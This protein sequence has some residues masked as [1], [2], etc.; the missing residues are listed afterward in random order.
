MNL[1]IVSLK[2]QT[3][4]IL[5][6]FCF[7]V[8]F[9]Q[10]YKNFTISNGLAGNDIK[11]IFKD[12]NGLMWIATGSGLCTYDGN[13][14]NIIGEDKGL[15]H[16]L[17][18]KITE[19]N[20]K[21]IWFSL[22]GNGVAKYDGR[23]FT[24]FTE[25]NGLINNSVR[26]L[27]YSKKHK[28]MVF[29]TE[30][31][32]S[33]F[34]GKKFKSFKLKINNPTKK[35][36]VNFI[37]EYKEKIVF[38]VNH[39]NI[40]E[41]N[42]NQI[43]IEKSQLTKFTSFDTKNYS[44]F[45][46]GDNFYGHT[47]S[48]DFGIYNLKTNQKS[49]FGNS[50]VIW[51]YTIDNKNQ[52]Y[53]SCW[54]VNSPS[55]ALLCFN[56][57]K[58]INLSDKLKLPTSLFWCLYFDKITNQLWVG[59][60]DKGVFVIDLSK[61]VNY[62]NKDVL[63]ISKPE[64]NTICIDNKNNIWIGGI[65]FIAIKNSKETKVLSNKSLTVQ[66]LNLIKNKFDF[67]SI[68]LKKTLK[69]SNNF[70]CNSIKIDESGNILALTNYGLISLDENLKVLKY[71][72]IS[73]TGGVFDIIDSKNILLSHNYSYSYKVNLNNLD[74]YQI[75]NYKNKE[76]IISAKRIF[77]SQNSL[78]IASSSKGLF[79]Y[80]RDTLKSMKDLGYLDEENIK[81][82]IV[83]SNKNVITGSV[84]GKVYFNRWKN[85][86]LSIFKIL[87]PEK[88]IIGNS[89]FFIKQYKNYYFIGTNK[90]LNII[91]DFKLIKFI[92]ETENLEQTIYTDAQIDYINYR[93]LISTNNG[94]ISVDL[95]NILKDEKVNSLLKITTIKVNNELIKN[96]S[97]LTLE[98]FENN[99]EISFNS[100]NIYNAS[101]NRY[102]YKIIGLN[103]KWSSYSNDNQI[104]LIGLTHG[105]YQ[106][107]IE[108]KN[109]GTN[110]SISPI[111]LNIIIN[112]PFWKTNWFVII[113][114]FT[115]S[116]FVYVYISNKIKSIKQKADL[117]KRI[118]ETKLQALQSQM[119]PHFV[120]N[121]MNSIQ[122]FVIDNK[123]DEALWYM[124]EF[125]KLMRQTLNYSSKSFIQLEEE[126]DYLK[127]YIELENLR[128]KNKVDYS[129][130]IA[131]E[132]D[133]YEVQIPPMLIQPLIE[134]VFVHAFDNNSKE[135]NLKISFSL[136]ESTL[137]CEIEDNG[138]GY[139][140]VN[141]YSK[142][143]NLVR[144]RLNISDSKSKNLL[145]IKK[146][147]NGTLVRIKIPIR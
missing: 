144:E 120:F 99:L 17:V 121:A 43:N 58:L 23:K 52:I 118:A 145:N 108:G 88:D 25:K 102:R 135:C 15:K 111:K 49:T 77:K 115:L 35:F 132:I 34:N 69:K 19:D 59:S 83:D 136:K 12:S 54:D 79:L 61:K 82:V 131:E 126:L 57:G 130:S 80:E 66:I 50:P 26:S 4:S 85:N 119:N 10:P 86:K 74:N 8:S 107:I 13:Q 60:V 5:L 93:L 71:L 104:K 70:I 3:L 114:I 44:G 72:F 37:S 91:K 100:N 64:I 62:L 123:T 75:L 31:G 110:E 1:L 51:D 22:Y 92:D 16:N 109:I 39:Y 128:R 98:H 28:C 56:N 20:K 41:L 6:S 122:N 30:D 142:G 143:L 73:E 29:G 67:T 101:K 63:K 103:D 45:I 40:Y 18:W 147:E 140:P 112:P 89:I 127:R 68:N 9:S 95:K 125:S 137:V 21:N 32:L 7:I 36:Q 2:K 55:G 90:G 81:D 117:E 138:K 27:F 42:I 94:I 14:F 48:N 87:K 129:V 33:I 124:G 53:A 47:Y 139:E 84:N 106:I 46:N 105:N 133:V 11:C 113:V 116:L 38:G 134:N 65:N 141:N 78:W 97:D 146:I 76:A 24:Y 96:S